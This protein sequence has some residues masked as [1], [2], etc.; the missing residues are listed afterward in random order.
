[1]ENFCAKF[2]PIRA[3]L[4]KPLTKLTQ[5][6]ANVEQD[7]GSEQD[8]SLTEIK[9]IMKSSKPVLKLANLDQGFIIQSD[10][11]GYAIGATLMQKENGVNRPVM[12]ASRQLLPREQ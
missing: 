5:K 8:Q 12:Y 11:S 7:W 4:L 6:G 9:R 3:Q 10:A 2:I 1:M